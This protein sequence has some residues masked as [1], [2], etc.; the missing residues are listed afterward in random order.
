MATPP[1][2][3]RTGPDLT[4]LPPIYPVV[5]GEKLAVQDISIAQVAVSQSAFED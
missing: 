5:V 1:T 4:G 3:P 2:C